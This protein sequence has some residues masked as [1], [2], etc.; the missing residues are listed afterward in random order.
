VGSNVPNNRKGRPR[1]SS[2]TLPPPFQLVETAL[3]AF[4]FYKVLLRWT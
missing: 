3:P 1:L 2:V 4:D